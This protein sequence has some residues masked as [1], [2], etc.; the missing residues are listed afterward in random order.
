M[1]TAMLAAIQSGYMQPALFLQVT[2]ATTTV[3]MWTGKG[4]FSWN[5]QTWVGVGTILGL[6]VI[7]DGATV[8]A[9][10]TSITLSGLDTALLA[11][12][13]TE[14]RLGLPVQI[15][16]GLFSGGSLINDPIPCWSGRMDQPAVS[17]D[18][19]TSTVRINCESRLLDMNVASDRRYTQQDQQMDW[20]GDLGMQMVASIQQVTLI[21][22]LPINGNNV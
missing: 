17:V 3:Y 19:A 2:F 18:G 4:N 8:E 15:Y 5:G 9:R 14:F 20:P 13:M 7:E 6:E 1:S 16:F 21:W 22:G 11:N 10:G 12:C